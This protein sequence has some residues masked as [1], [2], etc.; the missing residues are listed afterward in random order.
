SF[1]EVTVSVTLEQAESLALAQRLGDVS[2]ALRNPDD[3]RIQERAATKTTSTL[4]APAA[5]EVTP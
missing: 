4:L 5:R 2:L 1:S 3:I